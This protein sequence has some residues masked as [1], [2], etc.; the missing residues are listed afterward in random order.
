MYVVYCIV[1]GQLAVKYV[2]DCGVI[3]QGTVRY[4]ADYALTGQVGV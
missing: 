4:V 2:G 3:E 1:T